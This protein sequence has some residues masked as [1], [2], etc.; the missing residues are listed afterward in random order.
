MPDPSPA[1]LGQT[2]PAGTNGAGTDVVAV[3]MQ[4]VYNW[5]YEPEIDEL[6]TLYANGL[7]RQWIAMRDLDWGRGV[8][9]DAFANTFSLGGLPVS[10]TRFWQ[11]LPA[12]TRWEV[13]RRSACF[14]LSNFLHG[15]QGALMVAGQ[16]V[17]A[18]PHMDGKFYA[19][20]QTLDEA[21]HVEVFAAY[22]RLL[23]DVM[24]IS[25]GL[26]QL[27]DNVLAADDWHLKAVGMQVV[28]EGLALYS[29]RDMRNQTAEPLLK[30]LLTLVARDEARHTGYGI[31]YLSAVLPTLTDAEKAAIEDFAFESARLLIDSR[32]GLSVR[33]Q[34]FEIWGAAGVDPADAMAKLAEER[35]LIA[36]TLQKRGGRMGPVS[37]FVIPTLR[38]I[39]LYSDRIAGHFAEMF[40]ANFG[41]ETAQRL[42]NSEMGLPEDLEAWVEEGA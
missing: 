3:A 16:L 28:A 12:D 19:A 25:R 40:Q 37:G 6:R 32:A 33:E 20:T 24:E 8:D 39:G 23:D 42:A 18:V 14:M 4:A 21:R 9:R 17:N 26:K 41:A 27:L 38:A 31:K 30:Q 1:P 22:V 5:N 13:A 35:E 15:E 10:E 2:H 34:V 7:E 11:S 36:A 29:F